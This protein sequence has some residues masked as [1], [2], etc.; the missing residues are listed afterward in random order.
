MCPDTTSSR[1]SAAASGGAIQIEHRSAFTQESPTVY[2]DEL[3]PPETSGPPLVLVHGGAHTGACYLSTADGRPGWAYVFA[4]RNRRVIVPDWPGSGRS[5]KLPFAELTGEAVCKGLAQAIKSVGVPVVLVT[6][7]M[8]GAYGWRLVEM[9]GPRIAALVAVAPGPPGNIQSEP[10]VI[11]RTNEHVEVQALSLTWRV[12]LAQPL[13]ANDQLVNQKLVGTST[14]FPRDRLDAYRATLQPLAPRL[15]FERQNIDG[16]Q[17]RVRDTAGF[18]GKPIL[19]VTGTDD[20]DHPRDIDGRIAEWLTGLGARVDYRYLA[21]S[22][23]VGNGHMMMLEDNSDEIAA[24]IDD[25][26]GSRVG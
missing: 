26:I 5:G 2:F 7:S 17:L 10:K 8:S 6:H 14:R 13:T 3:L 1:Q 23:I 18:G 22:G 19:I 21:D 25:W 15:L 9:L 20:V 24:L 4:R 11:A 12:P 16:S